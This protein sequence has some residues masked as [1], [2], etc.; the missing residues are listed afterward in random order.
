MGTL[1][2]LLISPRLS[3]FPS[4][5]MKDKIRTFCRWWTQDKVLSAV[6]KS[7]FRLAKCTFKWLTIYTLNEVIRV[8]INSQ[9]VFEAN[10]F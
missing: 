1:R 5:N 2:R 8:T 4:D 7:Q 3:R 9:T 6:D 10:S